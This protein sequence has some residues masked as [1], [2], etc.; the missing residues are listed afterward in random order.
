[1][2]FRCYVSWIHAMSAILLPS[3]DITMGMFPLKEDPTKQKME[4]ISWPFRC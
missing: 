3:P 2:L 1:M 4:S